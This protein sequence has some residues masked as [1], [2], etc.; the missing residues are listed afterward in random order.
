MWVKDGIT[1]SGGSL[2]YNGRRVFN[3]KPRH[4]IEAGYEWVEPPPPPEPP[5]IP[6]RYS[7]LK[8]IR[9]LGEQWP[10]YKAQMEEAGL[11]DQFMAAEYMSEDDPAFAAFIASV[12]DELKEKLPDCIWED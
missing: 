9:E 3:P 4:F 6:L 5:V 11:Y 12:P 10:A 8:I 2:V 7:K 1:F